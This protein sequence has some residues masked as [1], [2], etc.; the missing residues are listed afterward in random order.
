MFI[1]SFFLFCLQGLCNKMG[2]AEVLFQVCFERVLV[3]F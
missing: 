1:G 2:L 3:I